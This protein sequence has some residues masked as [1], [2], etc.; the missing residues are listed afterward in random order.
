LPPP[1]PAAPPLNLLQPA[2]RLMPQG[3][4]PPVFPAVPP[5]Q[6]RFGTRE[7]W[8]YMALDQYGKWR[9]KVIQSPYGSYYQ[10]NG[11][12]Y[13]WITTR[14]TNYMPYVLD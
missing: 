10:Y 6:P 4:Y 8:Q 13:P 11:Q 9:P 3:Y 7:V 1:Q 12:P 14:P 5:Q 2:P